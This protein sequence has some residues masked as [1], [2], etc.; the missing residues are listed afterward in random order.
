MVVNCS[1]LRFSAMIPK[2]GWTWTD[3]TLVLTRMAGRSSVLCRVLVVMD[4]TM[5]WICRISL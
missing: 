5:A 3:L 1:L 4:E 2:V